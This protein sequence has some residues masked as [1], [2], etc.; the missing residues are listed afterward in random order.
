MEWLRQLGRAAT[1]IFRSALRTVT[2]LATQFLSW[3]V[4]IGGASGATVPSQ[5]FLQTAPKPGA[6]LQH[7]LLPNE[8]HVIRIC[9]GSHVDG[10]RP[11]PSAFAV[12]QE[13]DG[14]FKEPYISIYWAEHIDPNAAM[15]AAQLTAFRTYAKN[16]PAPMIKIGKTAMYAIL[17]V[18][19]VHAATVELASTLLMCKHEPE[20]VGDAHSGVH[21]FPPVEQWPPLPDSPENLAVRQYLWEKMVHFEDAFPQVVA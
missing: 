8:H 3:M 16:P 4:A 7:S 20:A 21:P 5:P 13:I 2:D 6:L 18:A 19:A 10:R 14:R 11:Q 9:S 15:G 17:P 12:K 1:N